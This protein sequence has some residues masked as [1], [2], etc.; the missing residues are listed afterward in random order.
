MKRSLSLLASL[1]L[2]AAAKHPAFHVESIPLGDTKDPQVGGIDILPNGKV[3][4]AF[5]AELIERHGSVAHAA[6]VAEEHVHRAGQQ[7]S[8]FDWLPPSRHRALLEALVTY[9]RQ[10]RM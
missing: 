9:V 3:A 6:A 1:T 7:L 8:S 4:V 2:A 10:R 5:L